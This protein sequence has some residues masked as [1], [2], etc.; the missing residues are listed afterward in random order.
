M[1]L[2]LLF[3]ERRRLLLVTPHTLEMTRAGTHS[4]T[5][6]FLHTRAGFVLIGCYGNVFTTPLPSNSLLFLFHC[7]IFQPSYH[8]IM[9]SCMSRSPKWSNLFRFSDYNIYIRV[10]YFS[11]CLCFPHT[12]P[13]YPWIDQFNNIWWRL[14]ITTLLVDFFLGAFC[15]FRLSSIHSPQHQVLRFYKSVLFSQG[16]ISSFTITQSNGWSYDTHSRSWALLEK[17]PIV[18]LLKNFPAF[19]GTRSFFTVFTKALH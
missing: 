19:Y 10:L 1:K 6:P 7:C 16:Q 8:N 14:Q 3:D 13:S 15:F 2:S 5:R 18:Q 17:S 9:L 11:S 4:L 12:A